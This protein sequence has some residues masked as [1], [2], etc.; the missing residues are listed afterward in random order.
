MRRHEKEITAQGELEQVLWQGRVCHLAIQ[1][2]PL[3]YLVPL[4]YGYHDGALY[5]HSAPQGHKI[6][7]L[8]KHLR[9]RF[10]VTID[11]GIIEAERACSWGARFT[12]VMGFGRIEFIE[13]LQAKQAALH[14]LMAQYTDQTFSFEEAQVDATRIFKLIIE[15]MNGKKSRG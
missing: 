2:D 13:D 3:P 10:S 12:S 11:Y 1:D 5:F 15:S 6:E 7:L 14:I 4:N 8:E 9:A